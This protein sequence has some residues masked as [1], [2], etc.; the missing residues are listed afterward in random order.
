MYIDIITLLKLRYI[1]SIKT[2]KVNYYIQVSL[3]RKKYNKL[4]NIK[5]VGRF[6]YTFVA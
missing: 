6:F 5:E 2:I 1:M 4:M 3:Y